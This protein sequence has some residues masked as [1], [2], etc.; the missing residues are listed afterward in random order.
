MRAR[1]H[2]ITG[3]DTILIGGD[4]FNTGYLLFEG[5]TAAIPAAEGVAGIAIAS[6]VFGVVGGVINMAVGMICLKE[7]IQALKNGDRLL[8][9][10]LLIDAIFCN[11]IGIVMILASISTQVAALSGVAA[12]FAANPWLLPV[13]FFVGSIPVFAEILSRVK[14]IWGEQDIASTLQLNQLEEMLSKEKI[15]WDGVFHLYDG[16]ALDIKQIRT[17]YAENGLISLSNRM[18]VL[19][20]DMGVEAAIDTFKLLRDL[21]ER[22]EEKALE[23]VKELKGRVAFW[24]GVQHLRLFQQFL[25]LGSFV[26][27]MAALRPGMNG[28]AIG[29]TQSFAMAAANAIPL[30]MDLRWPF[31]RN[32]TLVVP[33]VE[34]G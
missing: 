14:N 30:W 1:F 26:V 7:A 5:F 2:P 33:Q 22:N 4:V 32:V 10:R 31:E 34:V 17:E 16:T 29:A 27:S 12:F 3:T 13:L 24:N 11:A 8:G 23:R 21:L 25:Y 6:T 19:Q 15:D 20:G 18:E 28:R 9:G